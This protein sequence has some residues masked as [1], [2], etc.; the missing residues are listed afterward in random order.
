[1]E[2][3]CCSRPAP[4]KTWLKIN[5]LSLN[6]QTHS[7][8][9][10]D[11]NHALSK[12]TCVVYTIAD[13]TITPCLGAGMNHKHTETS[14]TNSHS[15]ESFFNRARHSTAN[16]KSGYEHF[17]VLHLSRGYLQSLFKPLVP[18]IDFNK[19]DVS[20][21]FRSVCFRPVKCTSRRQHCSQ[22]KSYIS[23][24]CWC[25]FKIG[26]CKLASG[27]SSPSFCCC[28]KLN[29]LLQVLCLVMVMNSG[30]S[31]FTRANDGSVLERH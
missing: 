5:K 2:L 16:S 18:H 31:L 29:M 20:Q 14:N 30:V 25:R 7:E 10:L 1:M 28:L 12:Q 24:C 23:A 9:A 27:P 26:W 13:V 11:Y 21:S 6:N 15:D 19:T 8:W 3:V 17:T 4:R 22:G